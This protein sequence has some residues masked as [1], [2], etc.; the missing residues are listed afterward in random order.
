M[1]V[2]SNLHLTAENHDVRAFGEYLAPGAAPWRAEKERRA[3]AEI[4]PLIPAAEKPDALII[5]S[6]E[7]L[8]VPVDVAAFPGTR[9]LLIT[10]WNLGLRYL[11][12]LCA[13]F[14]FCFVDWPGYRLLRRAGVG[15]VHHQPLFGHDP[16]HYRDRGGYRNLDVS[17]CGNLNAGLHR[18]RNRLLARLA[19]WGTGRNV[20]LGQA[21]N[22]AYADVLN[23]SRLVFNYSIRGE[24]NMR[25]YEAMACGAVPLVEA[26]NQE[27]P[28][29]FQADRH[30]FSYEPDRLEARLESLLADP[31]RIEAVSREALRAVAAHAKAKQMRSLLEFAGRESPQG[32]RPAA[33]RAPAAPASLKALIKMRVL[34]AD[35]TMAEALAEL[36]ARDADLPGLGAETLPAAL[37]TFLEDNPQAALDAAQSLLERMLDGKDRP[38]P[39]GRLFRLRLRLLRGRWAEALQESEACL[40]ALE[41]PQAGSP[42][43]YTHFL[44][45]IGLGRGAATDLN[46]AYGEDVEARSRQGYLGLLRASCLAGR[47][48][49]LLALDRPGEALACVEGIP[50]DRF[51]SIDPY[52][53]LHECCLR[54]GDPARLRAVLDA[55]FAERPLDTA[56][57]DKLAEGLARLGD[58]PAWIAFLEEI[59]ILARHFL[60]PAQ[61]E[62]LRALKASRQAAG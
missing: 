34:G 61:V 49:A 52:P 38:E 14:D 28:M 45:P 31:A 41:D 47:A 56:V 58:K 36:R 32:P 37:L 44:P 26:G 40:R 59:L 39:L 4:L 17:F 21:F 19:K 20:H 15:N 43:A 53:L 60:T 62:T 35:Y 46:R 7:Y 50:G 29:L 3:L 24:A 30:Y 6:P 13:L 25:L 9:I 16:A 5:A 42:E 27:V 51:V 18:A 23:R 54:L 2:L 33:A 10:D 11:P 8:P 57:W 55:W 22:E 1:R 48:R 12:D